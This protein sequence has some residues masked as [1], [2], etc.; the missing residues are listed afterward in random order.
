M[1]G[2]EHVDECV[3]FPLR[4]VPSIRDGLVRLADLQ[5]HIT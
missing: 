2:I 3:D 5:P 4:R 1:L